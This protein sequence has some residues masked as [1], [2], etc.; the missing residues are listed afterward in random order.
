MT[1]A[2]GK[3]S[4]FASFVDTIKITVGDRTFRA[5]LEAVPEGTRDMATRQH[6]PMAWLPISAFYDLIEETVRQGFAGRPD[7]MF[8]IGRQ[9]MKRDMTGIYKM[10]VRMASPQTVIA[11]AASI[12]GTYTTNGKMTARQIEPNV[13]EVTLDGV[14]RGMPGYWEYQRGTIT[15]V[16]EQTTKNIRC[17]IREGG[18]A[19]IRTVYRV[20]WGGA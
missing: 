5:I 14:D 3:A 12:Y 7:G 4:G 6:M 18:G 8:D 15:G 19:G 10:F 16:M 1:Q 11:K 13:A 20:A 2:T 17:E 9:Q